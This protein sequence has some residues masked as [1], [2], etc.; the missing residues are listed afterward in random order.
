MDTLRPQDL[1]LAVL[2]GGQLGKMLL[3]AA[4]D[5]NIEC[6]VLDPD[7]ECSCAHLAHHFV[8]GSFSDFDTVYAFGKN[9]DRITIEIEH[10][11]T[12]ALRQLKKEGKRIFPDPDILDIIKDKGKQK[13]FY[14]DNEIPTAS[15]MLLD[16]A[17]ELR[18]LISEQ[19]LNFPFVQ[20]SCT[21]GYDGKG[22]KIVRGPQDAKD[23][24][25]GEHLVEDLVDVE[26]ELA[27]IV[28]RNADGDTMSYPPV[29]MEFHPEANLVEFLL[30][31]AHV[32]DTVAAEATRI[33]IKTIEAFQM[34]G[35][36]AVEMFLTKKGEILVNEVAPRP[37]NSGHHT[38]EANYTSQYQQ[39]LRCIFGIPLGSTAT[40][41][42]AVMVNI[43]GA[44]GYTGDAQYAGLQACLQ[45]EGV[46]VH[47][48]GKKKTKPFRKMGHA[49]I[50]HQDAKKA[51][52]LAAVI[53]DTIKVIS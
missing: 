13:L 52:A 33:A 25:E 37:H 45:Q 7:P 12:D 35:I 17:D 41:T 39:L 30:A 23:L 50:V 46:Y 6:H 2:G 5:W 43:L 29:E 1:K 15:F 21:A 8:C 44:E 18:E 36:L 26:K 11:N 53:K 38:I 3:E 34:E 51:R 40:R 27:V 28:A 47:L 16:N 24:L 10:V 22:V 49:T 9:A 31:P 19:K 42:V 20:K 4:S 32:S 14:E 48:Y